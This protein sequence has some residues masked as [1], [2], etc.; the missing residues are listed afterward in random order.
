MYKYQHSLNYLSK[1]SLKI[2]D[3][4]VSMVNLNDFEKVTK[5]SF[6]C[7]LAN[8]MGAYRRIDQMKMRCILCY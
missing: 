3:F 2:S 1:F 4:K 7:V 5:I 6:S 8:L